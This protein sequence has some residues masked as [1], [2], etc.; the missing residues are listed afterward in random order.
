M[1]ALTLI[2]LVIGIISL[3][4]GF[5]AKTYKEAKQYKV[6]GWICIALVA[7]FYLGLYLLLKVVF[8][9]MRIE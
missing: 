3:I 4:V 8:S 7:V 1:I 5:R 6:F 9:G 2:V